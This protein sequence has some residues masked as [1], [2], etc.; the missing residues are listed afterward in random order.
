MSALKRDSPE[1]FA[2]IQKS[3]ALLRAALDNPDDIVAREAVIECLEKLG[4]IVP[5]TQS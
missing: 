2:E 1:W 4:I 3:P 5:A